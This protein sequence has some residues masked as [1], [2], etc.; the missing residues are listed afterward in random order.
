[1]VVV[2]TSVV[3]KWFGKEDEELLPQ[4]F[5]LLTA[6]TQ[7]TEL[8]IAPE[9]LLYEFANA[10]VT[11]TSLDDESVPR[12][13]KKL[14][15]VAIELTSATFPFLL[16]TAVFARKHKISVYDASYAVLAEEKKCLLYSADTRFVKQVNLPF[17]KHL[18]E[19]K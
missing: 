18:S 9:L 2:D 5:A 14:Q 11:K 6:H 8:L 12:F 19:Y 13:L 17:V 10:L 7:K 3:Y 4:A 16:K 1:M 15:E